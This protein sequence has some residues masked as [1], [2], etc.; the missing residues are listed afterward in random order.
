MHPSEQV[1]IRSIC[2]SI[3]MTFLKSGFPFITN[4]INNKIAVEILMILPLLDLK[5]SIVSGSGIIALP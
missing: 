2:L 5:E 1:G 3:G 4:L